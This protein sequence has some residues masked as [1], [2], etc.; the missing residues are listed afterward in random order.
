M[1]RRDMPDTAGRPPEAFNS[2]TRNQNK[3]D[4]DD[5]DDATRTT[6]GQ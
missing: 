2:G 1:L 3:D 6:H 5:K 4:K